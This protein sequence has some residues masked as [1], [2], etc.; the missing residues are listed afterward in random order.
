MEHNPNP[1][2][3]AFY[4]RSERGGE[5]ELMDICGKVLERF[6][7]QDATEQ[8]SVTLPSDMYFIRERGTGYTQKLIVE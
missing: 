6:T 7:I 8:I 5:F 2:T 1:T 4:V 3:G